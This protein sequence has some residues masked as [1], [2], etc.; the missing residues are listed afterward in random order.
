VS[1]SGKPTGLGPVPAVW[2]KAEVK[3]VQA[4]YEA[5]EER[6]KWE[7]ISTS[8]PLRL[9][10]FEPMNWRPGLCLDVSDGGLGLQTLE[11]LALGELVEIELLGPD[12]TVHVCGRIVHRFGHRYGIS[13][14]GLSR[15]RSEPTCGE[16]F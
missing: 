1:I 2:P 5:P 6:R 9:R 8:I 14:L 12:G 3:Q 10:K 7:R 11:P 16:S 13:Y 15:M 4:P